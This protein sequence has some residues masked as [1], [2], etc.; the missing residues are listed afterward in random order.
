MILEH[1]NGLANKSGT[2]RIRIQYVNAMVQPFKNEK[3][4]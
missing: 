2:E 1:L 3:Y 4:C